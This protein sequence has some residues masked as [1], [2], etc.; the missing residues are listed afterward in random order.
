MNYHSLDECIA[1]SF[2]SSLSAK[3][4]KQPSKDKAVYLVHN[5]NHNAQTIIYIYGKDATFCQ[6][7]WK[8]QVLF[9]MYALGGTETATS[10]TIP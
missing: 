1:A 10:T 8:Y 4:L 6:F 5:G 7:I 9:L 2:I 3:Q